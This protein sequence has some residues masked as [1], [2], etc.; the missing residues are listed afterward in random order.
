MGRKIEIEISEELYS[1][2]LKAVEEY[3]GS[4]EE[5]I[6]LKLKEGLQDRGLKA[7]K[8]LVIKELQ[9][10]IKRIDDIKYENLEV[11]NK[12]NKILIYSFNSLSQ[13]SNGLPSEILKKI[14]FY[15]DK[16][17]FDPGSFY[18]IVSKKDIVGFCGMNLHEEP[19]P[20]GRY[21]F[22]Y[23]LYLEKSHQSKNNLSYLSGY[24]KAIAK[25]AK[26]MNIDIANLGTNISAEGLK[27]MDFYNFSSA[28]Y[29]RGVLNSESVK[30]V[31][32]QM[33]EAIVL[34]PLELE[35]YLLPTRTLP[36]NLLIE[37]WS[38]KEALVKYERYTI[39]SIEDGEI[40]YILIKEELGEA[41]EPQ[42]KYTILVSPVD[43]FDKDRLE[44]V[45]KNVLAEALTNK[46]D[47]T[48][49]ICIPEELS[50]LEEHFL[51]PRIQK[52]N[53][54]RRVITD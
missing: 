48:I 17:W 33:C 51:K 52:I 7:A 3:D 4:L 2:L 11:E 37:G 32:S 8:K 9:N 23:S 53:W 38:N 21:L 54:Y 39:N 29:I 47:M 12:G 44:N 34:T 27:G 1:E 15:K 5:Y 26:A 10:T 6:S 43:S 24:I 36:I 50:Y 30:V 14:D 31:P 22:V 46:Q 49:G 42:W 35:K 25:Q 19:M 16:G 18:L 28:Q 45:Y 20:Y 13:S 41:T 40:S